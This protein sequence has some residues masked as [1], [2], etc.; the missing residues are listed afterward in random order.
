VQFCC[1]TWGQMCSLGFV[2]KTAARSVT[3]ADFIKNSKNNNIAKHRFELFA[4][5]Q[6]DV[7]YK[8]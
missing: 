7:R 8:P 1:V 2:C 5:P 4:K 3:T 6:P